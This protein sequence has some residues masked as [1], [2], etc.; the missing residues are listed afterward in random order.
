MKLAEYVPLAMRTMSPHSPTGKW[1]VDYLIHGTM[2][3]L[4]ELVELKNATSPLNEAEETSDIMWF[5]AAIVKAAGLEYTQTENAWDL[6]GDIDMSALTPNKVMSELFTDVIALVD[7]IK[8][9]LFYGPSVSLERYEAAKP[10]IQNLATGIFYLSMQLCKVQGYD[11]GKIMELN[12]AKLS[13]RYGDKFTD[14]QALCRDTEAE[15]KA[16]AE[17]KA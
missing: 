16:M 2:G 17:S 14:V 4:T 15:F 9:Q 6:L 1:E 8:R 12:I 11:P 10:K 3:I 5:T 7:I 13:R